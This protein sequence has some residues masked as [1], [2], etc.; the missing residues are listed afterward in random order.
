VGE[1]IEIITFLKKILTLICQKMSFLE[2]T[3]GISWDFYRAEDK[4]T[5]QI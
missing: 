1:G 2:K 3:F 4:F 5:K